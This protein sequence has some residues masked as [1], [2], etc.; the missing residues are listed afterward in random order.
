MNNQKKVFEL[1]KEEAKH[2][3]NIISDD[4]NFYS[5]VLVYIDLSMENSQNIIISNLLGRVCWC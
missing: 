2:G 5:M 1:S 4:G 3:N